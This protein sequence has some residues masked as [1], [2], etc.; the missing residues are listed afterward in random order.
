MTRP[1][2]S[3]QHSNLSAGCSSCRHQV[4]CSRQVH[5]CFKAGF[6]WIHPC[7]SVCSRDGLLPRNILL[8]LDSKCSNAA[9]ILGSKVVP[10]RIPGFRGSAWWSSP[11]INRTQPCKRS[12]KHRRLSPEWKRWGRQVQETKSRGY[13]LRSEQKGWLDFK[14]AF[15]LLTTRNRPCQPTC[16]C[17]RTVKQNSTE[18]STNHRRM[19]LRLTSL[20]ANP[21][22]HGHL[23]IKQLLNR[24]LIC[25]A[26]AA[27]SA[28]D[29]SRLKPR[30]ASTKG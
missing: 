26:N 22:R 29:N 13:S 2:V 6:G 30:S 10:E 8:L 9:G 5:Y 18:P 23:N 7:R 15:L 20:P 4:Q 19:R 14:T 16:N 27:T 28:L 1:S 24:L 3:T 11:N 17:G 21:Q 12:R 25:N